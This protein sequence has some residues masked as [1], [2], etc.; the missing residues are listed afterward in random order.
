MQTLRKP[1]A[2]VNVTGEFVEARAEDLLHDCAILEIRDEDKG[3][4]SWYWAGLV[5]TG[6][7]IVGIKL[8]KWGEGWQERPRHL[9]TID[10]GEM[11]ACDCGDGTFRPDRPGGCRHIAALRQALPALLF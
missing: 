8:C 7:H 2:P 3:G 9:V 10:E 4:S 5:Q 1:L 11:A 6:G